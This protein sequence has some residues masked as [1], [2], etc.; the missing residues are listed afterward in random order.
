[1]KPGKQEMELREVSAKTEK[2]MIIIL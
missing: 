2:I 1:M